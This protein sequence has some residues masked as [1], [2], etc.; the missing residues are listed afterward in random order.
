MRPPRSELLVGENV[1]VD[2]RSRVDA[3]HGAWQKRVAHGEKRGHFSG[4]RQRVVVASRCSKKWSL[5]AP[6]FE[7]SQVIPQGAGEKFDVA[8]VGAYAVDRGPTTASSAALGAS[9]LHSSSPISVMA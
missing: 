1:S 5:A 9:K 4:R 3:R 2:L 6:I 8:A 7:A